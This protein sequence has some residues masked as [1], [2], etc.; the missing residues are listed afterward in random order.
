METNQDLIGFRNAAFTWANDA[1]IPGTPSSSKRNFTLR[2]DEELIFKTGKFNLI[3]GNTGSGKTSL[4]M[5]LLGELHFI[6]SGP[7]SWF[8]LP[9]AGGVAYAAQES[10]VQN[11]TIR[12]NILFGYPYDEAR[13][14]KGKRSK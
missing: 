1:Q 7:D 6:P 13:Y 3:V 4:I 11:E 12:D 9:R 8:N 5:A 2:I 14:K 10:W